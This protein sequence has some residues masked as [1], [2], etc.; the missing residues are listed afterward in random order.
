[1]VFAL[2]SIKLR[3]TKEREFRVVKSDNPSPFKLL[4]LD[5]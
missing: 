5:L 4:V 2:I 3:G 1:M